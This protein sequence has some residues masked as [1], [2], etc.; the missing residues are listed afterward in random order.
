MKIILITGANR[1]LGKGFVEYCLKQSM[2]VFAGVRKVDE[3]PFDKHPNLH[4][5]QLDVSDDESIAT[6]V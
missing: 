6:A 4:V 2:V 3:A 1:G 5:I